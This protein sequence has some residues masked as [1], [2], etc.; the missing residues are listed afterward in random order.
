MTQTVDFFR[1]RLEAMRGWPRAIDLRHPLALLTTRLP[2]SQ[3][4]AVLLQMQWA[5]AHIPISITAASVRKHFLRAKHAIKRP[6]LR[7]HDLRHSVAS[8]IVSNGGSLSDVQHW[9]GHASYA[10]S[11]RYAHLSPARLLEIAKK[12][13]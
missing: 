5:L 12:I 7:P 11:A 9:L 13:A 6:E 2:G 4:K 3:F 1:A 8:W 10:S